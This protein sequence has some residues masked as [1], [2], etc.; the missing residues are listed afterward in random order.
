[1][2]MRRGRGGG[3]RRGIRVSPHEGAGGVGGPAEGHGYPLP[4]APAGWGCR[5]KGTGI[6][7]KVRAGWGRPAEGY[8]YPCE[9]AGGGLPENCVCV[10]R[11]GGIRVTGMTNG[12]HPGPAPLLGGEVPDIRGGVRRY[13]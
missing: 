13:A 4:Q 6:P 9:G 1:M 5:Q 11:R 8:G 7:A 2:R 12:E 3:R 10:A